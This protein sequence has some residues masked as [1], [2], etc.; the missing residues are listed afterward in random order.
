MPLG[1]TNLNIQFENKIYGSMLLLLDH[2]LLRHGGYSAKNDIRFYQDAE[3]EWQGTYTYTCPY[4]Q[5]AYDQSLGIGAPGFSHGGATAASIN[6]NKGAVIYSTKPSS[7]PT[8]T[9]FVKDIN[10]YSASTSDDEIIFDSHHFSQMNT[11]L[12]FVPTKGISYKDNPYPGVW[13]KNQGGYDKPYA[14]GP[15]RYSQSQM[16]LRAICVADN[17]YTLDAMLEI[18]KG[19][20]NTQVPLTSTSHSLTSDAYGGWDGTGVW[21]FTGAA[22]GKDGPWIDTANV[23]RISR[24]GPVK[25]ANRNSIAGIVDFGLIYWRKTPARLAGYSPEAYGMGPMNFVSGSP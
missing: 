10:I 7:T 1:K 16:N 9:G 18:F 11:G 15:G 5:F 23:N 19:L 25:S 24:T 14:I 17:N 3:A 13:L 22:N 2:V 12:G 20:Q 21:D 4:K 8:A 6:L